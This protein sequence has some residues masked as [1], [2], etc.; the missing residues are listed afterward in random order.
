MLSA[1]LRPRSLEPGDLIGVAAPASPVKIEL[2]ERGEAALSELGF[3]LRR[4]PHL[5]KRGRYTAGSPKERVSDLE[6]LLR[7]P[8]VRAILVARGGYGSCQ[9]LPRLDPGLIRN[10]PKVLM[11]ASD[12][13][14]LL[15]WALRAGVRCLHGPMPAREF[16]EGRVDRA[17][18]LRHLSSPDPADPLLVADARVLHRGTGRGVLTGGCLS[19]VVSSLATPWE[20]ETEGALLFLEDANT[21][22][23]QID[24]MLTQLAQ[25]GKLDGI[26]GIIFGEMPGCVQTATQ[27]YELDEV[28]TDLTADLEVP[29]VSGFPCGHTA[30]IHRPLPFGVRATLDADG[31]ELVFDEAVVV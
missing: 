20:I 31:K 4:A 1:P 10:D 5:L 3:R 17:E 12:A 13:T 29:V 14:S 11:G 23:Y 26:S 18:I 16:Q 2:L 24:R 6:G 15:L 28:L 9:L 19:I 7:D 30:G 27:G 25:A 21:K 8:E 22:P